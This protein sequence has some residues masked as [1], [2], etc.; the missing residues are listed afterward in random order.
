MPPRVDGQLSE[1]LISSSE[2][3]I[4]GVDRHG[5]V[6]IFNAQA[7]AIFGLD[8][9][10][11]VGENV[12]EILPKCEFSRALI[13]QIKNSDPEPIQRLMLFPQE[14]L[15]AVKISAVRSDR[16]RN[17]GAFATMRDVT[18]VRQV[19]RSLDD[20]FSSLSREISIP[21]TTIKGFVETLLEGAYRD[22]QVTRQFLQIINGEANN[23]VR[24]VMSLDAA[25]HANQGEL[26]PQKDRFRLEELLLS[27]IATFA[28]VA[29]SKRVK[30]EF[31]AAPELPW[32]T[33]DERL[34][35]Q[36]FVNLLD[37]AVRFVGV[38]GGGEVKVEVHAQGRE[39]WVTVKDNGIGIAPQ[40]LPHIFERFYRGH[41]P[42]MT[43]LGGSGLGLAV[44]ENII[45]AH[46]GRIAVESAPEAGATFTV[47]LPTRREEG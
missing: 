43:C 31:Y 22:S 34:L 5:V 18:G 21:L 27:C 29:E 23:L 30:I 24:L 9:Q 47:I 16:G 42:Q 36:V 12:W 13:G 17:L 41:S 15:Y 37:N 1:A 46:H 14:R 39:F 45:K 26:A 44:A 2:D 3:G 35:R 7:G 10:K 33:G 4:L 28:P 11:A 40:D 8:P 20:I 32:I 25:V 6:R 38:K 19:E